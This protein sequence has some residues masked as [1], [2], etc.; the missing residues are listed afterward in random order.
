MGIKTDRLLELARPDAD[1]A[2]ALADCQ[3]LEEV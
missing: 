1:V 2:L 3:T